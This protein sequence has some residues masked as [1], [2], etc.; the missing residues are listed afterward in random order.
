M[1]TLRKLAFP[2]IALTLLAAL[3]AWRNPFWAGKPVVF[4][5][6][7]FEA[8]MAKADAG[9]RPLIVDAMAS[10][11]GPCKGMDART[12]PSAKVTGWIGANAV[13]FQFDVDKSPELADRFGISAMPTVIVLRGGEE[14]ARHTGALSADEMVE[15]LE[16]S[17][18][19]P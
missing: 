12:W 5:T 4:E 17:A 15:W 11:C 8:A 7:T 10:W 9:G 18:E 2:L 1:S 3:F 16:K 19:R 6:G 14:V 13:A